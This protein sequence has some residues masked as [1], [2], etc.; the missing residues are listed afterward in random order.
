MQ[1]KLNAVAIFLSNCADNDRMRYLKKLSKLLPFDSYGACFPELRPKFGRY[2][3]ELY[4][5]IAKNRVL[6]SDYKFVLAFESYVVPGYVTEKLWSSWPTGAVPIYFGAPDVRAYLPADSLRYPKQ[7][8][9]ANKLS[10][11]ELATWVKYL[12]S[13]E[14][15][16]LEFVTWR[17]L[18][19]QVIREGLWRDK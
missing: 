6:Q 12:D 1:R 4:D 11:D 10:P 3:G 8:L 13:N 17:S 19:D 9:M 2:G 14:T 15:A 16:Y 7:V 5:D 18:G